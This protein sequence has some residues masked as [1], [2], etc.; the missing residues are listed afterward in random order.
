[1]GWHDD[2]MNAVSNRWANK[3]RESGLTADKFSKRM[4]KT[5]LE[6]GWTEQEADEMIAKA[7]ER[8]SR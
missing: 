1:M 5:L 8:G 3:Y 4:K 7:I 6:Y 2:H